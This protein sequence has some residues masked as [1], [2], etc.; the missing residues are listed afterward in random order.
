MK[1]IAILLLCAGLN[2]AQQ[3]AA[4]LGP[5]V[6]YE[7]AGACPFEGCVYRTWTANRAV[8]VLTERR[9]DAP[10]AFRLTKGARVQAV[11]GV[12]VTLK[13]GRVE[14][15]KPFDTKQGLVIPPGETLYLLTYQ[16]KASPRPGSG[17]SCSMSLDGSRI[18]NQSCGHVPERCDGRVV[19][20]P[21]AKSGVY[22][23][24]D[25]RGESDGAAS[26]RRSTARTLSAA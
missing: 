12:V 24:E 16:G 2:A 1:P 11:T 17:A 9:S 25:A 21:Y 3:S 23:Y 18:F 15:S 14:F 5:P 26:P 20:Q 7:D 22:S 19:E 6:R 8:A 10:I 4:R 13:A